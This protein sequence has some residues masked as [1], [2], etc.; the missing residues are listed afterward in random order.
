MPSHGLRSTSQIPLPEQRPL[1]T[2]TVV[3]HESRPRA[4]P[5][6]TLGFPDKKRRTKIALHE[7]P[8]GPFPRVAPT[9]IRS[10]QRLHMEY[11]AWNTAPG[12]LHMEYCTWN[13]VQQT[14][15]AK[16]LNPRSR[17]I[18]FPSVCQLRKAQEFLNGPWI[19]IFTKHHFIRS[20]NTPF[21]VRSLKK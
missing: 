7:Q 1:R 8:D 3:G 4:R 2:A 14:R 10:P 5:A 19:T 12:I 20:G 17:K 9:P 6:N 11:C 13:H 21:G 16:A 15:K 18:C